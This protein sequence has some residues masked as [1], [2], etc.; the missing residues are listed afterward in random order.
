MELILTFMRTRHF[1][2]N[3]LKVAPH[4]AQLI[5]FA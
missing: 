1:Q 5:N 3:S 4:G 2:S